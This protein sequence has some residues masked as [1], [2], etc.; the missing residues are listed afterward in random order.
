[1]THQPDHQHH[2]TELRLVQVYTGDGKRKTTTALGLA[3]WAAG[4]G[5]RTFIGQFMKLRDYGEPHSV[6]RPSPQVT[7]EQFGKAGFLHVN[8]ATPEDVA[9]AQQGLRRIRAPRL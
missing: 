6:P 3:L 5:Y 4:W 9:R 1:M 7:I 2:D 8:Q